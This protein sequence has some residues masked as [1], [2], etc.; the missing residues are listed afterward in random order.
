MNTINHYVYMKQ[1]LNYTTLS[2]L[3]NIEKYE[4]KLKKQDKEQ[5][6]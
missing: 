6:K 5:I 4:I 1:Y 2:N 3:N